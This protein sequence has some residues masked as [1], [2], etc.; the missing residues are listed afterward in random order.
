MACMLVVQAQ[1]RQGLLLL[2]L[3][4]TMMLLLTLKLQDGRSQ[5]R[6][7]SAMQIAAAAVVDRQEED[8]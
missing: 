1:A 6:D 7:P 4:M 2:L 5:R 8:V 3:M